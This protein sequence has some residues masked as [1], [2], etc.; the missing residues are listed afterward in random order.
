MRK[1]R[2]FSL[3]EHEKRASN[4]ARSSFSLLFS[5]AFFVLCNIIVSLCNIL[6]VSFM[7]L[8]CRIEYYFE[9]ANVSALF[10]HHLLTIIY[11]QTF[12]YFLCIQVLKSNLY[13]L[14]KRFYRYIKYNSCLSRVLGTLGVLYAGKT[15]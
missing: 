10:S 7:F 15:Y 5:H 3:I 14:N 13:Y 2:A 9:T 1:I 11:L 8:D 6:Y 12:T 4:E